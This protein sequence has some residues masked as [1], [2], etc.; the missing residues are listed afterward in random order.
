MVRYLWVAMSSIS[1]VRPSWPSGLTCLTK[2]TFSF[3]F[4][5]CAK[6]YSSVLLFYVRLAGELLF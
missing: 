2:L 6:D 5:I 4:F 3:E 1:I